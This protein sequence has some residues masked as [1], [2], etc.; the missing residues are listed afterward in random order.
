M[1]DRLF[2]L[3]APPPMGASGG[4]SFWVDP[5]I[6][7]HLLKTHLDPDTELASRNPAFM[8]ESVRWIREM[9]P[10]EDFPRLID[11]GCGP[12]LYARRFARAGYAV[13]GVD[14]SSRSVDYARETAAREG[15]PITCLCGDYLKADLPGPFDLAVMIYCDY[16]ALNDEGRRTLMDKAYRAL[17]PGGRFLLDVHSLRLYDDFR[18]SRTWEAFPDGG[19]WTAEKHLCFLANLKYPEHTTLYQAVVMTEKEARSYYIWN[20]CFGPEGIRQEAERAGFRVLKVFGDVA[21]APYREDSQALA[22]LL[23]K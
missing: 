11:L 15:L 22:V 19:F 2:S 23:E 3:L 14:F 5:H 7:A 1:F 16:G 20:H 10:P 21:G 9:N 18:E 13:T 17:R 4:E 8:D 6:S 12:G